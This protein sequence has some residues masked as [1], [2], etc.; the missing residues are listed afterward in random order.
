MGYVRGSG[1]QVNGAREHLAAVPHRHQELFRG[2]GAGERPRLCENSSVTIG[3]FTIER[4]R[5]D[6]ALIV[7]WEASETVLVG[8]WTGFGEEG[9][10]SSSLKRL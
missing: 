7:G 3:I 10:L 6:F 1:H 2:N 5:V 4:D 8:K 9:V